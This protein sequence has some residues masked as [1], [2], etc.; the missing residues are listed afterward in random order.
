MSHLNTCTVSFWK[1]YHA[2][3]TYSMLM[4]M[5]QP[6]L[7][8]WLS[9]WSVNEWWLNLELIGQFPHFS[10]CRQS[11]ICKA[12][13]MQNETSLHHILVIYLPLRLDAHSE[14][15]QLNVLGGL[16]LSYH[17]PPPTPH[18]HIHPSLVTIFASAQGSFSFLRCQFIC[19]GSNRGDSPRSGFTVTLASSF[20]QMVLS[21]RQTWWNSE[22]GWGKTRSTVAARLENR[23]RGCKMHY[24]V[25]LRI[26]SKWNWLNP[27]EKWFV[28]AA[29]W[30]HNQ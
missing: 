21:F 17:N 29:I 7:G 5:W 14:Q 3:S 26:K 2:S 28:T 20:C 30:S 8:G 4:R 11:I 22:W 16:Q 13:V 12:S 27:Y 15:Y 19:G 23:G 25:H 18:T 10:W 24:D 9:D 6:W 1:L